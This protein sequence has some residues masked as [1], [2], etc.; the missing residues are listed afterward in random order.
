MR[1]L[2]FGLQD[3]DHDLVFRVAAILNLSVL[4]YTLLIVPRF[5]LTVGSI[6]GNVAVLLGVFFIL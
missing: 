6:L 3:L 2:C 5:A 1:G 4:R